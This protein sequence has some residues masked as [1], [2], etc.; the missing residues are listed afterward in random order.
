MIR[1]AAVA[2]F[3]L[4]IA[5]VPASAQSWELS[6]WA[7]FTPAA[8][9]EQHAPELTDLNLRGGFT[10]GIQ[11]ARFFTPRW[12][13]EVV[14]TQ[15]ASALEGRTPGGPAEFYEIALAQVHANF[16]YQFGDDG[17]KLRPFVFGGAG[18]TLFDAR[19]L[20]SAA[21]ASFGVGGGVKYFPWSTIGFRGQVRI[22][23]TWLNDDPDSDLCQPFGFCQ[24]WVQP[25]ELTAGVLI[26][27]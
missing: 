11:A 23:P 2:L 16:V 26:R 3:M 25:F 14:F 27:F 6:G 10:F 22:K 9:L 21:K 18:T 20:E 4:A 24:A 19:D 15:Q 7:G 13:I 17:T 12:G 5:S 8:G 1:R